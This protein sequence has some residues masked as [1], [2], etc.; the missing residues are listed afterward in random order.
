MVV[1]IELNI[2]IDLKKIA[3]SILLKNLSNIILKI[4]FWDNLTV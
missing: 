2:S 4:G 1:Y 3:Q